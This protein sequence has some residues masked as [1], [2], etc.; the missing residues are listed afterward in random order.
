MTC[1]ETAC[2]TCIHLNVCAHK[3][4]FLQAVEAVSNTTVHLGDGR[5][6]RLRDMQL[7]KPVDL[8][9]KHYYR[10]EATR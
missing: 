1:R 7:I 2:T 3:A 10:A 8:Q 4:E 9:C 5:M 6:I